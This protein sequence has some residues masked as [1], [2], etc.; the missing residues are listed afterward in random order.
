[1]SLWA[2]WPLSG[3]PVTR[4][5]GLFTGQGLIPGGWV[6]PSP[7]LWMQ[8]KPPLIARAQKH[9]ELGSLARAGGWDREEEESPSCH[10]IVD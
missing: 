4:C 1:M 9:Q 10:L 3:C 8:Q 2:A 7:W 6:S 5:A